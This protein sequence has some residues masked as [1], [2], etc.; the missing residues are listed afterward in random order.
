MIRL[1][2]IKPY[3]NN[4]KKHDLRINAPSVRLFGNE[5]L[6]DEHNVF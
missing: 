1:D 5:V 2:S 6:Y 4:A 3:P